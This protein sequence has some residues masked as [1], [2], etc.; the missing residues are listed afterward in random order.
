M[1]FIRGDTWIVVV[2]FRNLPLVC[3]ST[4]LRIGVLY[5]VELEEVMVPLGNWSLAK[6]IRTGGRM[7]TASHTEGTDPDA[8]WY[9]ER[10]TMAWA[11]Q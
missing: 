5:D 6:C 1:L 3:C 10:V 11:E 8:L 2:P 4:C 9:I 7:Q